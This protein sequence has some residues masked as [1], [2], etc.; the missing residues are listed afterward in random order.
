MQSRIYRR[1]EF[2]RAWGWEPTVYMFKQILLNS[3]FT[4]LEL[5]GLV[6]FKDGYANNCYMGC[7]RSKAVDMDFESLVKIGNSTGFFQ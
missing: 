5:C 7:K 4:E 6:E 2:P 3:N 1:T